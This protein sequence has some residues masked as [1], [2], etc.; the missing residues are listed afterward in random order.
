MA[1]SGK[2]V[3]GHN[4]A[5]QTTYTSLVSVTGKG[6]IKSIS[7]EVYEAG[8]L[9]VT[10]DGASFIIDSGAFLN[11]IG[12]NTMFE[13][14]ATTPTNIIR[15]TLIA[16]AYDEADVDSQSTS[17]RLPFQLPLNLPFKTSFSVEYTSASS[18]STYAYYSIVYAVEI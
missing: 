16:A 3:T 10:I 15:N 5:N 18:G 8:K 1:L 2:V 13:K 7:G 9:R 17:D 14:P 6:I 4:S 11:Q 12:C